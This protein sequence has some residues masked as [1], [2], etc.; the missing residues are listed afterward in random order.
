MDWCDPGTL[1]K[2]IDWKGRFDQVPQDNDKQ[3]SEAQFQDHL[4][5]LLNPDNETITTDLSNYHVKIPI[6][7]DKIDVKECKEVLE[8]QV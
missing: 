2:A 5:K 1:W 4:E 7:D 6:L 3:P 8:S